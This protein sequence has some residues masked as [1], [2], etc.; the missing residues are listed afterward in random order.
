MERVQYIR[1]EGI[2]NRKHFLKNPIVIEELKKQR[3]NKEIKKDDF[4]LVIITHL[5]ESLILHLL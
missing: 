1:L 5:F 2:E 4:N 3:N